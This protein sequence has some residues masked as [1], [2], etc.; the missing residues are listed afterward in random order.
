MK[1]INTIYISGPMTDYPEF[2]Y[3]AFFAKEEELEG[4]GYKVQNPARNKPTKRN[5]SKKTWAEFMKDAFD[6]LSKSTHIY[7]LEGWESSPG[8]QIEAI[9]A[10][11]MGIKVLPTTVMNI[12]LPEITEGNYVFKLQCPKC[13][14]KFTHTYGVNCPLIHFL[15]ECACGHGVNYYIKFKSTDE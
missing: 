13:E 11:R 14:T 12:E 6:M 15:A 9:A 2:N 5:G 7:F 4:L 8:A 3:P 1:I 10:K